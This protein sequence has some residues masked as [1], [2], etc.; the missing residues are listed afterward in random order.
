MVCLASLNYFLVTNGFVAGDD[1]RMDKVNAPMEPKWE[2][3]DPN[4]LHFKKHGLARMACER[5]HFSVPILLNSYTSKIYQ[6]MDAARKA[7]ASAESMRGNNI[8]NFGISKLKKNFVH[9]ANNMIYMMQVMNGK[10]EQIKALFVSQN[11]RAR[12]GFGS[13]F[14]QTLNFGLSLYNAKAVS[15]LTKGLKNTNN[16]MKLIG[17]TILTDERKIVQNAKNILIVRDALRSLTD[18]MTVDDSK[19]LILAVEEKLNA[20][21]Y[22]V[23]TEILLLEMQFQNLVN[24]NLPVNLIRSDK[25]KSILE[26]LDTAAKKQGY[27]VISYSKRELLDSPFSL[28]LDLDSNEVNVIIHVLVHRN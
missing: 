7:K 6:V 9:Q 5:A 12:H 8:T 3:L 18:L 25:L 14:F 2:K 26:R 27:S 22:E 21:V 4:S 19:L 16:N 15:N 11:I 13:N 10:V 28:H 17:T 23:E 20:L 1:G 24:K